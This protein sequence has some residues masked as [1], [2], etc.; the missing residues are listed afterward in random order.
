MISS[1]ADLISDVTDALSF[2]PR[3][4][5]YD[6][7]LVVI[8]A[9]ANTLPEDIALHVLLQHFSEE[10]AGETREKIRARLRSISIG[11]LFKLA[12]D[13][14]Y[15]RKRRVQSDTSVRT[16]PDSAHIDFHGAVESRAWHFD[17]EELEER[18][19]IMEFDGGLSRAD[20]DNTVLLSNPSAIRRRSYHIAI[21]AQVHDKS[22]SP[23]SLT[24]G[25]ENCVLT[26]DQIVESV[27]RAGNAFSCATFSCD[28]DGCIHRAERNWRGSELVAIDVDGG[29]SIDQARQLNPFDEAIFGYTTASHTSAHHRFRLVFALPF[30][31]T[32]PMRYRYIVKTFIHIFKADRQCSDLARAFLGNS[33][34]VVIETNGGYDA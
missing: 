18:A 13:Y 29:L 4:P 26:R 7:W 22:F 16:T 31:E 24:E 30:F 9:V 19:A 23:K 10:K 21:N 6:E 33:R 1:P 15:T 20:A 11:S 14:G 5:H 12:S 25:F 32:D 3:R 2:I 17:D 28:N 34:A 27:C 8:S